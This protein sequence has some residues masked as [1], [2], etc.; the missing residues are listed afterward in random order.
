[1]SGHVAREVALIV[2]PSAGGGRAA[3]RCPRVEARLR[4]LGVGLEVDATRDLDHAA[5]ARRGRG[6]ARAR[7]SVTLSG[8]GML[9]AVAG[10]LRDVPGAVVGVLPG[11]RGNDF[12]RVRRHP[13]R[14]RGGVRRASPTACARADRPRPGRR[15]A[16]HRDRV[17]RLR[18]RRQPDR[19]RGARA[20]RRARLRLRRAA[21][22]G[23]WKPAA[24][25]RRGRR[26]AAR[27]LRLGRRRRRTPRPT[28]AACSS[29]PTPSSTTARST[30][31]CIERTSK[32][33][34][35]RS[36]LP[37][38]FKGEHVHE[39]SVHVL[40]GA[41]VRVDADRPFTVYADGDPIGE[42]PMT[43]RALPGALRVLLPGMTRRCCDV[44]VAAARAAGAL[45]R[46]A[47]RGGTSLPGKLL[48]RLE[49]ARHRAPRRPPAARQRRDL[50]HQRQDDDRGDGRRRSSSARGARLVHNR[51]GANMAG[52]VAAA[53][54]ATARAT[55]TP[56]SSRSTSSGSARSS[57]SCT[58][59]RCCWPTCS[60]TSSTATASSTRSPIAGRRWRR[61]P[62]P[63]WS[64][65]PTTPPSPTSG[66]GAAGGR[67]CY[68]GV[69]DDAMALAEMQHAADAKHCRRCGAPY[70]YD[71][72]YLGH[73]GRYHC[74]NCGAA[75]PEPQV[76]A[77][78]H[79]ARGRA[80]RAL[81]AAH[82]AGRRA[83]SRCPCPGSTTSTTRSAP[84]RWRWRSAR[85]STRSTPACTRS[86][87]RSG[88]PRRC[89][90]AGASCR[91]CS[92]R[93]P[94]APT[95]SCARSRSRTAS[96]TV[97]PCSTTTSPTAAT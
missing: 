16:L 30:S 81:H 45:S 37:K 22:A 95:R 7:W 51:A 41:E 31:S 8:D 39:P 80:R 18:L 10:A 3:R 27:V 34:F 48:M 64:S 33:R 13:A 53:L 4:A 87:P 28:A 11:G 76:S 1:M 44:K 75:R 20:P 74:D 97:S 42:L 5:R 78:R 71:A 15:A 92:S 77:P 93:T 50:G 85:P 83:P 79:R 90:S 55:A 46:R 47:G 29:R 35:L 88:A 43:F 61:A 62:R 91:S 25:S 58:R 38:V 67:R 63:R 54:H 68:F 96:T 65:T 2:N 14:R 32:A 72:V 94:P 73:L 69:Q 40:R 19:Q 17:A 59:A 66:R 82:A 36:V 52:G 23:A 12:A 60:A 24:F 49:P 86:P 89:A 26:R 6:A 56:A 57:T 84:R 70:R 21:R 9:G